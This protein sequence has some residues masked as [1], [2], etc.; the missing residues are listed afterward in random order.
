[1]Q[2]IFKNLLWAALL[3]PVA[4]YAQKSNRLATTIQNEQLNHTPVG[5]SLF[6]PSLQRNALIDAEIRNVIYLQLDKSAL[7]ALTGSRDVLITF[8]LPLKEGQNRTFILNNFNILARGFKAYAQESDGTK[9]EIVM[10]QGAFYR[11]V[12]E[13]EPQSLAAF[14]FAG[15]EVAAVFST[16]AAG[17]YNLVLNYADPG[18]DHTNYILFREADIARPSQFHCDVEEMYKIP[19]ADKTGKAAERGTYSSCN[20]LRVSMHGDYRLYQKKNNDEISVVNYLTSLF[21]MISTLYDNEGIHAVMSEAVVNVAPDGYTFANSG[22]VLDHF[23]EWL[24]TNP[25]EGDVAHLV[26]GYT[27]QSGFPPLGGLAWLDMLCFAPQQFQGRWVGP[28]S[29]ANNYALDNIPQVPVY[30]WDVN[31]STHEIGHNIGS[32]HTQSC[33]WPGGAIDDCYPTEGG[34]NPGPTPV[35]GGTIM[36]YCHLVQG[37]GVNFANGFGP[38]P[39]DLIRQCIATAACL[40]ST[41][42]GH[43]LTTATTVRVANRQCANAGW[44]YFYYDNLTATDADDE[45]LLM[46]RTNNQDLGNIDMTGMEVK[47]T[48]LA[49]GSNA[50]RTVAAPYAGSDWKEINRTWS[51]TLPGA[52]PASPVSIRFPFTNQDLADI[53]GTFPEVTNANELR[54]VAFNN[55]AAASNPGA[56]TGADVYYYTYATLADATHWKLNN[57]DNYRTAEFVSN[58]GIFGGSIGYAVPTAIHENGKAG[59]S[60]AVYPNPART[61][62][63]ITVPAAS[64]AR[65][66]AVEVFDPLGRSVLK[67]ERPAVA[68]GSIRLNVSALAPGI[69]SIRYVSDGLS[70]TA[71]F[72]KE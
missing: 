36:S 54:V 34:C 48:T 38:L 13:G 56:A 1:M 60:L 22:V 26:T 50:A 52:Q 23:S 10:E 65:P 24:Q 16:P 69:Y 8:A 55:Q 67:L 14:T 37:V 30:S 45:L 31:A 53:Q 29:M 61:E 46:I 70:G 41:T 40:N 28:Y 63:N 66:Q 47:M 15:G 49:Y 9:R 2:K 11:G 12:L 18:P 25:F 72:V 32:P 3:L 57:D 35:N 68:G 44:T 58:Y 59:Y 19:R 6:R 62:L 20:Q 42:P 64:G 17:N 43:T 33:D 21:N 7:Q 51:V 5:Y 27:N 71:L 39:G 4:L